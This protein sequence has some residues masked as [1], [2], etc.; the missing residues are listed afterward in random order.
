MTHVSRIIFLLFAALAFAAPA[1]AKPEQIL[2]LSQRVATWQLAHLNA[3]DAAT[4]DPRGWVQGSFFA[5][6]TALADVSPAFAQA[7]LDAG[8][9]RNWGLGPRPFHADDYAIAQSWIWAYE[10]NRDPAMIAPVRARFDTILQAAPNGTLDFG[11]PAPGMEDAC[12]S[13]WCWSDALFMGPPAWFALSRA[14]GDPKYRAYADKEYW[15]AVKR[16]YSV[17]EQLFYRDTR[18]LGRR[19]PQGERIFWSRG[20]GWVYAGLARILSIL[21]ADAP[22]RPRYVTLF[23]EMSARL[24]GLQ[25]RDGTWPVSLLSPARNTPPETSGTGFFTYGL[26]YGVAGGILPEPRY[27]TAAEKGWAA[28]AAAVEPDGKLGWVQ[29]IGNAPDQVSRTD[30]QL[31]GSGAFLFAGAAMFEMERYR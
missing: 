14:T 7:V 10:R 6:L 26:A 28:L 25:K 17:D 13:R 30:T 19:G 3:S 20:N 31:Y 21:P 27:R 9:R 15:V 22:E 23:R 2:A 24:V 4:G 5:G 8:K 29:Q 16:L 18:F 11:Q 1:T 12:Q